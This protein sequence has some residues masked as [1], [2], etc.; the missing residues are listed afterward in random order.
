[1]EKK[2]TSG[3][4]L[5]Q[6]VGMLLI[7]ALHYGEHGEYGAITTADIGGNVFFVQAISMFGWMGYSL[8]VM[9]SGYSLLDRTTADR[10]NIAMLVFDV[11]FFTAAIGLFIQ[12]AGIAQVTLFGLVRAGLTWYVVYY[13][14]FSFFIP[15]LNRLLQALDK[16]AFQT[17][18]AL[19]ALFCSVIPTLTF[20]QIDFSRMDFFI[21]MYTAGAYI[22]RF[23]HGQARY[24]N[25]RNLAVGLG[26]CALMVLSVAVFDAMAKIT[27]NTFFMENAYY[28]RDYNMILPVIGTVSLFLFFS[29]L[30]FYSR[31]VNYVAGSI[32]HVLI[33]HMN[34]Y[35][36]RWIWEGVYPNAAYAAWPYIHAPVKILCVFAGC[37]LVSMVY[38]ATV[39][40]WAGKALG[41]WKFLRGSRAEG[42][43]A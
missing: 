20:R 29:K 31:P 4:E 30:E 3:L 5:A 18:L 21:V 33:I 34:A 38:R 28:F 22:R 6:L 39:R 42:G 12:A 41:R 7:I 16:R 15:F 8:L 37:L 17:L 23:V 26:A 1:M 13:L 11:A 40:K 14:I 2:K 25:G 43:G 9:A 19:M 27:G 35:M 36:R 24:K 32:L 10:P